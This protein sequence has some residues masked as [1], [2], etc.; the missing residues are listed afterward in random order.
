MNC[1]RCGKSL[2]P[3]ESRCAA[4]GAPNSEHSGLFQTST[5]LISTGQS[6]LVYRS[7]DEVPTPLRTRL[8]KSTSSSNAA[9]ILIA[10]QRGRREIAR[11]M[12]NL[13]GPAQRRLRNTILG[14]A[15]SMP[16]GSFLGSRRRR[17]VLAM[18]FMLVLAAMAL[19]F[20]LRWQ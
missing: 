11:A 9:T 3:E 6:D 16:G 1:S 19:V 12:R 7:V 14:A 4:C 20:G 8:L 17:V 2:K 10:D 5:V 18:L 13:P 15:A